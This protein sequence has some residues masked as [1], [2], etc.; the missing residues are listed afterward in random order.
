MINGTRIQKAIPSALSVHNYNL[1]FFINDLI[2]ALVVT[3]LLIPQSLAYAML[4]G[5][6][7]EIGLYASIL[8]LVLYAFFGSS[9]TLSVGPVAVISLLTASVLADISQH[10]EMDPVTSAVSLA[11]LSGIMLTLLGMLRMGFLASFLSHSVISGFISASA[12]LIALSQFKHLLGISISGDSLIELLP[13]LYRYLGAFSPTTVVLSIFAL[14]FL[15]LARLGAKALFLKLGCNPRGALSLSKVAPIAAVIVSIIVVYTFELEQAGVAIT[16]YIPS[17]LPA[18]S[19]SIPDINVLQ[20]LIFPAFLI[21][22]IGYVESISVGKTLANKRGEKVDPNRELVGLGMANLGSFV[23]GGIAVTGGFSRTIVNYDA[24]AVSQLASIMAA[25][26][27][28]LATQFF[29]PFLFYLP[30]AMLA[31]TIVV[32]IS[33][34]IDY[35]ILKVTWEFDKRDFWAVLTTILLTLLLG[36]E[37]GVA[38]GVVVSLVLYIHRTSNPHIAEV[39]LIEGTEH[40]RNVQRHTVKCLPEV[41]SIRIDESLFFGNAPKIESFVQQKL[42]EKKHVKHL[43]L[44]CSAVNDIDYSSLE[45]LELLNKQL[46]ERGVQFHLSEIKGPLMDKLQC[47]SL[48]KN[49]SGSVFFTQYEAFNTLQ[50]LSLKATNQ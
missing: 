26:G 16:G 42:Q 39:G 14:F 37:A 4:A 23:S 27:I 49:L 5:V 32:A 9:R 30:K 44:V 3:A 1:Q 33:S 35:K 2:A 45:L 34:L 36:V 20:P 48:I 24:G 6:P 19:F 15:I 21:S 11:L 29:T 31:A 17:G 41:L 40:F 47:S 10:T 18:L 28:A 50:N 7:A 38:T 43:V 13:D 46:Q 22:L 8:P 12:L 25:A